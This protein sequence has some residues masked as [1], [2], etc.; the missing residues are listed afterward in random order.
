MKKSQKVHPGVIRSIAIIFVIQMLLFLWANFTVFI[1]QNGLGDGYNSDYSYLGALFYT[2]L[3]VPLAIINAVLWL[4]YRK[5]MGRAISV[6]V[7]LGLLLIPAAF[8][9]INVTYDLTHY[10]N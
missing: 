10:P 6:V 4:I 9:S 8:Y 7:L 5:T 3:I 1:S 2:V